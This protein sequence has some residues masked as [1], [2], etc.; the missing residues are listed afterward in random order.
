MVDTDD[1]DAT[2]ATA[3]ERAFHRRIS[4]TA[5][6]RRNVRTSSPIGENMFDVWMASSKTS[7]DSNIRPERSSQDSKTMRPDFE[8]VKLQ[9]EPR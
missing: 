6:N 9:G 5:H 1:A 4:G 3:T 7:S 2:P 8:S